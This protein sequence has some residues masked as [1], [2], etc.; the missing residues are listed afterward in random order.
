MAAPFAPLRF[1]KVFALTGLANFCY[2]GKTMAF[3]IGL[4]IGFVAAIPIGPVNVFVISQVLKRDF[5]HGFMAGAT[6]A[7]LDT[8]YCLAAVIG[9]SQISFNL[10]KYNHLLKAAAAAVLL[11]L[12]VRLFFQAKSFKEPQEP[13]SAKKFSARSM[14][15]VVLLYV[16]NPS[17]YVF[18]GGVAAFVTSHEL[19]SDRGMSPFLF[20]VACG[21]GAL[22]WSFTL[23]RYVA[24]YHHL[25]SPRTFHRIF[26]I[27]AVILLVFG[28]YTL[29]SIFVH[30]KLL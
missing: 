1:L 30:V 27:L 4:V 16:T 11:F 26:L 8:I 19:V 6:A 28:I 12:A 10:N 21:L 25:F 5:L 3:L 13:K 15:G 24:K 17:L 20:A 2:F 23:T 18:W 22:L 7:F 9:M 29:V 14:L